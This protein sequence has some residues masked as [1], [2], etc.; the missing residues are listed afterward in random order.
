M[1][2]VKHWK[3]GVLLATF[4]IFLLSMGL[5]VW[6]PTADLPSHISFSGSILTDEGNQ[7]HNSRS[8]ALY[9]EWFPDDWRI[10]NYNPVLPYIKLG[11]YKLFGVGMW[12]LRLT[13]YLFAFFT[14]LLFHLTLRSLFAPKQVYALLGTLLL[15]TNFLSLMYN[16][17]ATFE[18]SLIFWAILCIWFM[19]K[20]RTRRKSVYLLAATAAAFT[21]FI[22]KSLMIYL[23]PVP[24]AA[25]LLHTLFSKSISPAPTFQEKWARPFLFA[26]LGLLLVA[27]PWYFLHYLPN[28]DWILGAPG[29]YMSGLLFP[30]D[31]SSALQNFM[32]FNWKD[33]FIKIPI[34]WLGSILY[35]PVFFRRLF[36]R[37]A[38][39]TE[40][41][42]L[43]FFFAHTFMFF[44]VTYRPTRYLVPV[45]PAMIFMTVLLFRHTLSPAGAREMESDSLTNK[46]ALFI[47]DTAWLVLAAS[48][49]IIPLFSHYVLP[50]KAPRPSLSL[51][52]ISALITAIY[53]FGPRLIKSP[54]TLR[55]PVR[56]L[57]LPVLFLATGLS[58]TADAIHYL[59]WNAHKTYAVRNMSLEMKEK[60]KDAYICGMTSSV[61]VLENRHKTL[62]LYP[63]FTN[64]SPDVLDRYGITHALLGTDVSR[65]IFHFFRQWP[66]KM[67]QAALLKT[68]HIKNYFLH[69]YSLINPVI[70]KGTCLSDHRIRLQIH[71]PQALPVI[72]RINLAWLTDQTGQIP[73]RITWGST[74][75]H[76]RPGENVLDIPLDNPI[77]SGTRLHV[78]LNDSRQYNDGRALRYEGEIFSSRTGSDQYLQHASNGQ[79][80]SW[81]SGVDQPGFMAYGPGVPFGAGVLVVDF[82]LDFKNIR[83]KTEP[84]CHLEIFSQTEKKALAQ[85]TLTS[86]DLR[87]TK[88]GRFL[89]TTSMPDTQALEFRVKAL[90]KSDIDYDYVEL[91]YLQGLFMDAETDL[92]RESKHESQP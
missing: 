59:D 50:V 32:T 54:F 12:Q 24:I 78:S 65:E 33:Q 45:I 44:I 31:I 81:T 3:H 90:G 39:L 85:R 68:Y 20:Y 57:I 41:A 91:T 76:L 10:T 26:A 77:T 69:F 27:V 64:W 46:F 28:R 5:R 6:A 67:N 71:N 23:V 92:E 74:D 72:T 14:L 13:N 18:T 17:I 21:G 25:F 22:F 73:P 40:T 89:L 53:H 47:L 84:L 63:G 36:A 8:K 75:Y 2:R 4:A 7:T 38:S 60:L 88:D 58:L 43:A 56:S 19:E 34:V 42:V 61:A 48:F 66:Q 29:Q 49:C 62:W 52:L 37:K 83:S 15:G 35:L 70:Q 51:L 80:R 11:L 30:R 1:K 82:R 79:V 16:R 9:D 87:K 55:L 86:R